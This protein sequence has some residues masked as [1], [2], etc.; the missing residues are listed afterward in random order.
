MK[1]IRSIFAQICFEAEAYEKLRIRRILIEC[2]PQ[3]DSNVCTTHH[4][5]RNICSKQGKTQGLLPLSYIPHPQQIST[6]AEVH[7]SVLQLVAHGEIYNK[8]RQF[9]AMAFTSCSGIQ[10]D[11][12]IQTQ[13]DELM[14]LCLSFSLQCGR[15][16]GESGPGTARTFYASSREII[17]LICKRKHSIPE[18]FL[19]NL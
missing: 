16:L 6:V 15:G 5:D 7:G 17:P 19:L 13:T 1:R 8:D 4:R 14:N 10:A 11:L 18:G 3:L 2:L 9:F 12:Q